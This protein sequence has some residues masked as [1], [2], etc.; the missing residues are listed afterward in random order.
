MAEIPDVTVEIEVD[1]S[2]MDPLAAMSSAEAR[3]AYIDSILAGAISRAMT[4]VRRG[5]VG[6]GEYEL[7]R[8]ELRVA[9][10][11]GDVEAVERLEQ[12]RYFEIGGK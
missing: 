5:R 12:L 11:L 6:R 7:V 9:R 10:I 8:A 3:A 2:G 1:T 4:F